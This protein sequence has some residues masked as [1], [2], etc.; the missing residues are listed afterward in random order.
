MATYD[1]RYQLW[2][3]N[4]R[5][6]LSRMEPI[7]AN[8]YEMLFGTLAQL[9]HALAT[10]TRHEWPSAPLIAASRDAL[11]RALRHQSNQILG[12]DNCPNTVSA[13]PQGAYSGQ[14]LHRLRR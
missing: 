12:R 2:H 6:T 9:D 5:E 4:M 8:I 11:I 14:P 13:D 3:P 7:D 1:T 10:A